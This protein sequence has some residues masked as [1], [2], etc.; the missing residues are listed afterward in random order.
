MAIHWLYTPSPYI[1]FGEWFLYIPLSHFPDY[2]REVKSLIREDTTSGPIILD[3]IPMHAYIPWI[4]SITKCVTSMIIE[5]IHKLEKSE[6]R[7]KKILCR[8]YGIILL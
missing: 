2:T 3:M 6:W 7:I 1:L 5:C 4:G 8:T